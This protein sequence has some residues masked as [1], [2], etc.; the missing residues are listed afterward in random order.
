MA[1][2]AT[3]VAPGDTLLL[4]PRQPIPRLAVLIAEAA[5]EAGCAEVLARALPEV[6]SE[7]VPLTGEPGR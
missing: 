1:H 4:P 3:L 6:T 5:D 7:V 2:A